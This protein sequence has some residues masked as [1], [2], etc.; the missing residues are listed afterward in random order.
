LYDLHGDALDVP[1]TREKIAVKF[2]GQRE[3]YRGFTICIYEG[4]FF[5]DEE[6]TPCS[7][8]DQTKKHIDEI[9]ARSGQ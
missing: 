9:W 4:K 6:E 5:V 8:L 2:I 7:S 3:E 1:K